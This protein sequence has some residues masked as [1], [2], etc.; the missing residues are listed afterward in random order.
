M[1]N[2]VCQHDVTRVMYLSTANN[3]PLITRISKTR[4]WLS[5]LPRTKR[6]GKIAISKSL[7]K[8]SHARSSHGSGKCHAPWQP[9]QNH[10]SEHLGAWTTSESRH[11]YPFQNCWQWPPTEQTKRG[12][13]LNRSS[14]FS[15]TQPVRGINWT[16]LRKFLKFSMET[17]MYVLLHGSL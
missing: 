11:F 9:L 12:S 7:V 10:P 13:L 16:E 5:R 4:N 17:K 8:F 15:T 2:D 3:S 1:D 6:S 14:C